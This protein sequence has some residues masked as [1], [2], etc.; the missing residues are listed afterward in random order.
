VTEARPTIL[1]I[2]DEPEIR[3]FLRTSLVTEGY[4]VV[5][6]ENGER[7]VIEAGTHKPDLT[8]VDLGLPDLDGVEVIR[9][10]RKWSPMPIVVLSARAREQAKVEALDAGADDYVTKPFGVGELLARVRVA[11]RHAS[12]VPSGNETLVLGNL[13]ID[14]QRRHTKRG[15]VEVHLT[16]IEFRLL[17][18]LAQHLGMV[19]THRQLLREVWGPSFVEHTHYLRIYM[20]QLRDKLE[21]DPIRPKH[22]LTETGVG[23]RLLGEDG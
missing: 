18:C 10:I 1:M 6:A 22:L 13:A 11:L 20:N 17:A 19:V 5:E 23:Y 16:P 21:D 7:G 3:L 12:R 4:R 2:E 9:R 8:I 15:G 14:L